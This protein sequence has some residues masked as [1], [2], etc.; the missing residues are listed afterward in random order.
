M[1]R[2]WPALLH[3]Q[4]KK[5]SLLQ[6]WVT[7]LGCA[8][9]RSPR[10]RNFAHSWITVAIMGEFVTQGENGG[11]EGMWGMHSQQH[12]LL[13]CSHSEGTPS[14]SVAFY[15][16][17]CGRRDPLSRRGLEVH[18]SEGCV[19][20]RSRTELQGGGTQA[21][22]HFHVTRGM[23]HLVRAA[24]GWVGLSCGRRLQGELSFLCWDGAQGPGGSQAESEQE[25]QDF[26]HTKLK[27]PLF[28]FSFPSPSESF[29]CSFTV[30]TSCKLEVMGGIF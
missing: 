8:E 13:L 29:S 16:L 26:T 21:E 25:L 4:L 3:P 11:R 23:W 10:G 22:G 2:G 5:G 20:P 18:P 15:S 19:S 28:P 17:P 1:S 14:A 30:A 9:S 12:P 7:D 6:R 24:E 27:R